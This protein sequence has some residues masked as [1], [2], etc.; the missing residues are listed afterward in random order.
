MSK[1]EKLLNKLLSNP[2]D[3]TYDEVVKIFNYYG[4][5]ENRMAE[6]SRVVFNDGE[7]RFRMHR[8]HPSN[9]IKP[10]MVKAIVAFLQEK[11]GL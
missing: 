7:N 10:Y 3:L 1:I 4:Y 5:R 9:I 6:G 2:K 11:E 8:P